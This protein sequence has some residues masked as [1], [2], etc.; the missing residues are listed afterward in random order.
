MITRFHCRRKSEEHK[1]SKSE[2][3]TKAISLNH[4]FLDGFLNPLCK[5]KKKN[6][7]DIFVRAYL[8]DA[9]D[10]RAYLLL[11]MEWY[12]VI[13]IMKPLNKQF[14]SGIAGSGFIYLEICQ[15]R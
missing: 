14:G 2:E 5:K 8:G 3:S 7:V 12:L 6:Q 9:K 15:K 11:G 4:P 1:I 13:I 10:P